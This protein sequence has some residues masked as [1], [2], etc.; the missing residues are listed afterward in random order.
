MLVAAEASCAFLAF[1]GYG[2]DFFVEAAS[3]NCSP[4]AGLRH[5][6]VLILLVA[7]NPISLG[8]HLGSLAHYHLGQGTKKSVALHAAVGPAR[9]ELIGPGSPEQACAGSGRAIAGYLVTKRG[10]ARALID[11]LGRDSE[12]ISV[13]S[14]RM[15]DTVERL[16]RYAQEAGV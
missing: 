16:L 5:Q 15:N 12:L 6:S 2:N 14:Q 4:G 3:L 9:G 8:Q 7:G 10:L 13:C 11:S 1:D